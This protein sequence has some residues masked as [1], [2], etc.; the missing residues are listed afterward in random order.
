MGNIQN[1]ITIIKGN[2][3]Y[4]GAS[5]R[6]ISLPIEL[7]GDRKELIDSDRISNINAA[8]QTEV[9]RQSSTTFR[10]GGKISNIFSNVISGTTDYDGYKNF[11]YLTNPLSVVQKNQILFNNF[12]RVPD[13]FGLKWAGLP[14]YNE[15]NFIRN[16]VENPHNILQP[17]SASTYNWGVYLTYPFSSDTKQTMS[18]VDRQI[19][20]TP[21]SFVVE[22]GIPFTIINTV[23]R[24]INYITFRC[25]GN[26][27]LT[28][29][30]Y[31]EL[32]INYNGNKLFKVDLLGEDGFDN[33]NSSFSIINPGYTGTTFVNGVSGTF[34]RIG[35]ISNSGESKSKYYVRLH[36]VL[37]NE[38]DSDISKMGF[39]HVPFPNQQKLEYSA[40]T[41]NLQ[42]RVSIKE[43]S[44]SYSFT[45]KKD[46]NING[47]VDNNM[48]PITNVFVSI[49]N[50]GYYGWF[51]K[52]K[53]TITDKYGLQKGWSFNFH[54]DSLDDWWE[55]N[56]SEN[57]VEIPVSSYNKVSN[58]NEYTFYYN[59]P[60]NIGDVLSGDFCEY[61]D[62]EQTEYV[63]SSCKH[64]ITFNDTLYQ[65]QMFTS[66]NPPGYFYTP[67]N[68]VKLRDFADSI[69]TAVG[70]NVNTRPSWAYFSQN[71]NTWI[72]RTILDYGVFENGKGVDYPFL[73]DAHYPFSQI[74]FLQS[75]PY[76]N[77]NQ[78]VAVT[79]QPI[80]DFC[81]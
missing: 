76:S 39:E 11:L 36:K 66:N 58:G 60:L 48:K 16:D 25:G 41:P 7:V 28:D 30:Q 56:S 4:K 53:P 62:I 26:H 65:T 2:L 59:Q 42:Q 29:Y 15:F 50:K 55:T 35:D 27:N 1:D 6:L 24:G 12:E 38:N 32:S 49:V 72:W 3:R 21:L 20:G 31:V 14:Q 8:E 44:Q 17:Q 80:K 69:N 67:H 57:L 47:L 68:P 51:N 70:Q 74:L 5:E 40:L 33:R 61:N 13:T 43:N 81:E 23:Q 45:F 63:V 19:N 75:T 64:K 73:N 52:P 9:E 34:K 71:L 22:D 54:S 18:Y 46:L 10:I 78:S 37:T 77:I 79:A